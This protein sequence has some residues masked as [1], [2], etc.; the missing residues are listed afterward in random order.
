MGSNFITMIVR[1]IQDDVY[2]VGLTARVNSD[3]AVNTVFSSGDIVVNFTNI[4][5]GFSLWLVKTYSVLLQ[6]IGT[7]RLVPIASFHRI[8]APNSIPF[9]PAPSEYTVSYFKAT[10]TA[11]KLNPSNFALAMD[12]QGSSYLKLSPWPYKLWMADQPFTVELRM[13]TNTTLTAADP[14][15]TAYLYM[16]VI[17]YRHE[18]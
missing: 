8:I 16:E 7:D 9:V 4:S 13:N 12:F 10:G 18:K 14:P 1:N 3:G 5:V 15:W 6:Q 11:Q 17:K 2:S